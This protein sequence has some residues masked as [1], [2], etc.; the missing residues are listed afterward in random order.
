ME[1]VFTF[2]VDLGD[3]PIKVEYIHRKRP[4]S[5]VS[6]PDLGKEKPTPY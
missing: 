5:L 2:Y 1:P 6:L 4:P 3:L